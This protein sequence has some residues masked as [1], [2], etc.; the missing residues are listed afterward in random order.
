MG[1]RF[2]LDLIDVLYESFIEDYRNFQEFRSK[3]SNHFNRIEGS[4]DITR[5]HLTDMA[6]IEWGG[7][8]GH[9]CL[10]L[11][12]NE[13]SLPANILWSVVLGNRIRLFSANPLVRKHRVILE[14][15]RSN[16]VYK[17]ASDNPLTTGEIHFVNQRSLSVQAKRE[18]FRDAKD[19]GLKKSKFRGKMR[20]AVFFELTERRDKNSSFS[21]WILLKNGT[22]ILWQ[23]Q[24]K[25]L[26]NLDIDPN[27]YDGYVCKVIDNKLF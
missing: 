18:F 3:Y 21:R 25:F 26:M 5:A 15:L 20:R 22:N 7:E 1:N 23:L 24:G 14:R 8:Y 17:Y 27:E 10:E 16:P 12:L 4:F 6:S 2:E 9:K 11:E 13:S 19:N